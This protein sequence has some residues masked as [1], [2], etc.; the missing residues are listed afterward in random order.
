MPAG[1]AIAIAAMPS[2]VLMGLGFT[3]QLAQAKPLPKNPFQNGPCVTAPDQTADADGKDSKAKDGDKAKDDSK[4][5]D[6]SKSKDDKGD[7]KA[8]GGQGNDKPKGEKTVTGKVDTVPSPSAS[9]DKETKGK[10]EEKSEDKSPPASP[11]SPAPSPSATRNPLDPLGIGDKIKDL[12]NG[13]YGKAAGKSAQPTTPSP[14]ATPT[15]GKSAADESSGQKSVTGKPSG[16]SSSESENSSSDETEKGDQGKKDAKADD[17]DKG[18]AKGPSAPPTPSSD[19][20]PS[21]DPTPTAT[22]SGEPDADGKKPYPCVV[23]KKSDGKDEQTPVGLPNQPWTLKSDLITMHNLKYH[24]VVNLRTAD[25][26]TKQALKFTMDSASIHNLDQSADQEVGGLRTY[27][28]GGKGTTSTIDGG[29]TMYTESLKGNLFG[30][31][32]VTFTPDFPPPI[33]P[34]EIFFT[35]F[36]AIQAGQFGGTLRIP[37]LHSGME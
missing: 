7:D 24:G 6:D 12:L 13:G 34:P 19:T 1:K 11:H 8:K 5:Q 3:P 17:V 22:P 25:G 23:E 35:G 30:V 31:L 18:D 37:G 21:P 27:V 32:P 2:A 4:P 29:V 10:S 15:D 9:G 26:R 28:R 16:D 33:T 14:T 36:T 20:T